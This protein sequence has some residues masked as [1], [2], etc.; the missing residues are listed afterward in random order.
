MQLPHLAARLYGT[1]LLINRSKLDVILSVLGERIDWPGTDMLVPH[2]GA[3]SPVAGS[4]AIAV[5][6]VQG[7]LVKRTLGLEANSGLTSYAAIGAM[8]AA[9]VHDPN[10][11]GILLDVDSPGGET[12]GLFEL[13]EAVRA[14]TSAKPVWA[15]VNDNAFSAAYAIASA[16]SR[17]II[18]RTGGVGSIGVIALHVD[19]SVADA[20]DGLHYTA[21]TAGTRKSDYS[22]HE[23]L[24]TEAHIRLQTEVNRL[25][26]IFVT[27][28]ATM[29]GVGEDVVRATEAGLYF[30]PEGVTAG[31]ADAVMS[32]DE[33]LTEFTTF[34]TPQGRSRSPA[35][36]QFLVGCASSEKDFNMNEESITNETVPAVDI[37]ALVTEARKDE[38]RE[39]QA[40]AELCI[41]AGVPDQA[42]DFIAAGQTEADVRKHLLVL[43][44]ASQSPEISSTL[45]LDKAAAAESPTS[46]HNPL[47]SAVKKII[48]K[49]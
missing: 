22:P 11:R 33:A 4:P 6:P 37:T 16:A 25:Y 48:A 26:D 32:L 36:A 41:L 31:L 7:T 46:T 35:R 24:S 30:G 47:L 20:K 1:P 40:I 5:I 9:A 42:A 8:L 27:H 18:T 17:V 49:E 28:V 12:G 45:D 34:I 3:R 10:V 39:I 2:P 19:Q 44:A 13:S 38:R 15:V 29:R 21:I 14:A 23:P 43:K